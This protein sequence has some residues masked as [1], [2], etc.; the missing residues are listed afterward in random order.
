MKKILFIILTIIPIIGFSQSIVS[1]P[2]IKTDTIKG[3]EG[4]NISIVFKDSRTYDKKLI[5]NC[6]KDK[7]FDSFVNCLMRTF[8]EMNISVLDESFF[9]EKPVK[10]TIT[11]KI[12]L[13]KYDA[14]AKPGW[15]TISKTEYSVS[16]FDYRSNSYVYKDTI[17]AVDK[18]YNGTGLN[19]S[20]KVASNISFKQAFDKFILMF[21]NLKPNSVDE[22]TSDEALSELKRIK[23]KLDL[24]L[25]TQDEYEKKKAELMKYIK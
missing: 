15:T 17:S 8:P 21:E 11:I 23:E 16:I 22:L 7:I 4:L 19:R 24:Q 10:G 6:K 5:E 9:E 3:F 12:E 1:C 2:E 20:G 25:I 13:L 18:K 14:T